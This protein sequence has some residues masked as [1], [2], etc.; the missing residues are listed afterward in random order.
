MQTSAVLAEHPHTQGKKRNDSSFTEDQSVFHY[1]LDHRK[2]ITRTVKKTENGVETVTESDNAA[3]TAKIKE[4]VAAMHQRIL[5]GRGIHL[6]DPLFAAIFRN[7]KVIKMQVEETGKGVKVI[8][9]STDPWVVK[10][11]QAHAEVVSKFIDRG[12]AEVQK[13]HEV[14]EKPAK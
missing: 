2:E 5:E 11:I 14:P 1:L 4:H 12:H 13:N 8:E 3:V 6:W 7:A 10:L 9:T